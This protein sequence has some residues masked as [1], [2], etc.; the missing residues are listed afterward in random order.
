MLSGFL[1]ASSVHPARL[2]D[3]PVSTHGETQLLVLVCMTD[4]LGLGSTYFSAVAK[5]CNCWRARRKDIY[6]CWCRTFSPVEAAP[7]R[8]VPPKCLK[9]RWGAD[10]CMRILHPRL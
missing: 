7:A 3:A 2:P 6:H 9:G 4:A 5:L 8:G 1:L 10:L